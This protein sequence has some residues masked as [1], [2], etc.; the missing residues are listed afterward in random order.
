M[1]CGSS[2]EVLLPNEESEYMEWVA[3]RIDYDHGY[4]FVGARDLSLDGRRARIRAMDCLQ[5]GIEM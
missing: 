5:S 2:L 1:K 4:Y 3:S